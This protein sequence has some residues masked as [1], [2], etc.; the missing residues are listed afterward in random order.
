MS[1]AGNISGVQA[2]I[3][4]ANGGTNATSFST[5]NGIVKYDGTR[6]V[7][8]TTALIDASNR[9]T[10]TSQPCFSVYPSATLTDVTGDGTTYNIVYNTT[11]FDQG[12]NFS[13]M[14]YTCPVSG[15]YLF[16]GVVG[17]SGL[18][19]THTS[20]LVVIQN[21]TTATLYTVANENP[22]TD[23]VSTQYG[24]NFSKIISCAASDQI[25]ILVNVGGG[26]KVVDI[27]S[28]IGTTSFDGCLLC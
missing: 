5:T 28:G 20:L 17:F 14:T 8:S 18:L 19:G 2:P 3:S 25:R 1:Q 21:V 23:L 26:T 16:T 9:Q 24:V 12:S 7:T 4:I 13:G 11:A 15:K 6:L 10:N 27:L 22:A